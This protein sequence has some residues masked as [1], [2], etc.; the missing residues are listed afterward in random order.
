MRRIRSKDTKPELAVR[1]LVFN[2]GFRYRLHSSK[3]KG[4]PDLVFSR[5][6]RAIFV[7]DIKAREH[8]EENRL[9]AHLGGKSNKSNGFV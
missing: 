3:L 4:H 2:M 5:L 9:R 6:R 7:L 1:S 8:Q